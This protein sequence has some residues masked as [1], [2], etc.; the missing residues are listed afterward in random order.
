MGI[1][2]FCQLISGFRAEPARSDRDAL[3]TVNQLF[4]IRKLR[5]GD[6]AVSE[7]GMAIFRKVQ[8]IKVLRGDVL[9]YIAPGNPKIDTKFAEKRHFRTET[10]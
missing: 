2:P 6:G 5:Y 3:Y 7:A 10:S 9:G 8:E 1:P 4:P